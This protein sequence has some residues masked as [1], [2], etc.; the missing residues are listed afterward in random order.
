MDQSQPS[1]LTSALKLCCYLPVVW[2]LLPSPQQHVQRYRIWYSQATPSSLAEYVCVWFNSNT[3]NS[4]SRVSFHRETQGQ[5]AQRGDCKLV[6]KEKSPVCVCLCSTVS[7][8]TGSTRESRRHFVPTYYRLCRCTRRISA[9]DCHC[10]SIKLQSAQ[11]KDL[12]KQHHVAE[13]LL[14]FP[15]PPISWV[16]SASKRESWAGWSNYRKEKPHCQPSPIQ[17]SFHPAAQHSNKNQS[18]TVNTFL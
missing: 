16:T 17:W 15:F 11:G 8:N 14:L 3:Q 12:N 7:K 13:R 4:T 9:P 2:R 1:I 10:C 18:R 5:R 6:Y